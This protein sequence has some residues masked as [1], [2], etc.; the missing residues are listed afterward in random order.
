M[1]VTLIHGCITEQHAD[2]IVNAA[3]PSLLWGSGVNGA[4][5]RAGGP[6]VIADCLK[7]RVKRFG[8]R[9]RPGNVTVTH[10]GNLPAKWIIHTVGPVWTDSEDRSPTLRACYQKALDLAARLNA[11]SVAFPLISAGSY[12]WPTSKAIEHALAVLT[13][14][15][16]PDIRLILFEKSAF[17]QAAAL[18][19]V[20]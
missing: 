4:V 1:P 15:T 7:L 20:S 9:L 17:H 2:V 6:A 12:G 16:V 10:A 3:N 19:E 11:G 18:M 14:S 8:R 5:H 13:P